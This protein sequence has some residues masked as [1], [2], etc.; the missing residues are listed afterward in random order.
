[1]HAVGSQLVQQPVV[2]GDREHAEAVLVRGRFDAPAHRAERVD[3]EAGVDLVEDRDAWMEHGQLQRLVA[4]LLAAG[5]VDVER[6]VEEPAVEADAIRL[7]IDDRAEVARI[8]AGGDERFGKHLLEP[9]ARHFC[10]ILQREEQTRVRA[11]PRLHRE[12]VGAVERHRSS[13]DL[14]ARPPHQHVRQRRLARSVRAHDDVDLAAAHD[15]IDAPQD[16]AAVDAGAQAVDD[17]LGSH[18]ARTTT[19]PSTTTTSNTG[20]ARVAG[21]HCGSPSTSENEL[22]CFQHSISLRSGNTSP[23]DREMSACV[24]RSPIA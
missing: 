14:V 11:L 24:Q 20:V 15:Q 7:G 10:R 3:V 2:V 8:A 22:P 17:Q 18:G 19:R 4:L 9:D 16:L 1:V 5:Q 12:D 21:R 13:E 23:S 6:A